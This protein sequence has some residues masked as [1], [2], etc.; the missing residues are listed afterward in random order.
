MPILHEYWHR[1]MLSR[2]KIRLICYSSA[3][4]LDLLGKPLPLRCS[5]MMRTQR[6]RSIPSCY[7]TGTGRGHGGAN[8]LFI[9]GRL[10]TLQYFLDSSVDYAVFGLICVE[11]EIS[12]VISG[13]SIGHCDQQE[14]EM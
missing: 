14:K 8:F 1:K 9:G 5:E 12:W 3:N 11:T 7:W 6:F 10:T 13:G 2:M 4:T